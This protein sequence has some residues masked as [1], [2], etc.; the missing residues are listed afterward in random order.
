MIGSGRIVRYR[1]V[2]IAGQAQPYHLV[3]VTWPLGDRRFRIRTV[4]PGGAPLDGGWL[5]RRGLARWGRTS[6]PAGL[7]AAISPDYG[8]YTPELAHTSGLLVRRGVILHI[9]AGVV[10]SPSIGYTTD[11]RMVF[12]TPRAEPVRFQLAGG[13]VTVT[14]L[15]SLPSD[16]AGV[17]LY[18]RAGETVTVPNGYTAVMLS[19]DPTAAAL[20]QH[21]SIQTQ[22]QPVIY[23]LHDAAAPRR[24][25]AHTFRRAASNRVTVPQG[26]AVIVMRSGGVADLGFTAIGDSGRVSVT[27]TDTAWQTARWVMGGKPLLVSGGVPIAEKP[28]TMTPYQW[29]AMTARAA[30]GRTADGRGVL[31]ILSTRN[32]DQGGTNV[33]GFAAVLRR[34]GVT[35]AIGLDAGPVPELFSPRL[36]STTCRPIVSRFCY[37]ATPSEFRVPAATI[38]TFVR[39]RQ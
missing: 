18:R 37:R 32:R 12:G 8:S 36:R 30:V 6:A 11:D 27:Q 1:D 26:G 17:G 5:P 7:V 35:D 15:E 16:T 22:G 23:A 25:V 10:A 21:P 2:T 28:M 20:T 14:G 39:P 4:L 31:A 9:P 24:V 13:D 33:T 34:I 38:V 3:T 29:S 19:S